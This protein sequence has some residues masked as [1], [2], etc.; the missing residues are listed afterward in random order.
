MST[1][2]LRPSTL[3]LLISGMFMNESLFI[4]PAEVDISDLLQD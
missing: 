2:K 1:P 4:G 3:K